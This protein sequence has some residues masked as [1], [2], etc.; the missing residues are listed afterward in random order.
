MKPGDL[1]MR[2][3]FSLLSLLSLLSL[4][5]LADDAI[6]VDHYQ[7]TPEV[8]LAQAPRFS[9]NV[10][11]GSFAPWNIDQRVNAWNLF[12]N[13]EPMVLQ[14]HG[15]CDGGG[16]DF[17]QHSTSPRFSF[18]D[19]GRSGYWDGAEVTFYRLENG[20]LRLVRVAKVKR[21][22]IGNDPVTNEKTEEKL[23]LTEAGPA[24]QAGDFYVLRDV[25]TEVSPNIRPALIDATWGTN[26]T[27]DG[28]CNFQNKV[29][30]RFD[31]KSFA[32]DGGS[33]AS[34]RMELLEASPEKPAGPWHWYVIN[35]SD[36]PHIHLRFNPGKSYKASVWLRQEGMS[37]PRALVKFGCI[38]STVVE[39][40][41][42]WRKYE[43]DLP[44][45]N[46]AQSYPNRQNDGSRL[47][48]G[49]FSKGTLWMDNL[50]VWQTDAEPFDI[51]PQ[52]TE[53]LRN[54]HPD[55]L[56]LWSGYKSPSLDYWLMDG[57]AQLN[58]GDYGKSAAP[59][60]VSLHRSLKLCTQV[61]ADPW[62]ILNP[63]FSRDEHEK[64][65]EYLGAPADYGY[66]KLR[67]KHG[68]VKPWTEVFK[69]IHLESANEAWNSIFRIN[70]SGRPEVYAAF[71]DRQF[72]EL[73]SSP[74]YQQGKF[75][76][77]ANGW[78]SAMQPQG[79]THRVAMASK[80]ADRIDVACYFG[81]WEAGKMMTEGATD[82]IYQDKL[83][84]TPIEFGRKLV[85][86]LVLDPQLTKSLC[87]ALQ[88]QPEMLAAGLSTYQSSR[89]QWTADQLTPPAGAPAQEAIR[90][91]W[92]KDTN[93]PTAIKSVLTHRRGEMERCLWVAAHKAMGSDPALQALAREALNLPDNA[94]VAPLCEGLVDHN[95]PSRLLPLLKTNEAVVARWLGGEFTDGN[96]RKDLQTFKEQ[97]EKLTYNITNELRKKL[98][99]LILAQAKSGNPVFI[100]ALK[101][102][103]TSELIQGNLNLLDYVTRSMFE[104]PG[105]RRTEQLMRTMK[106]DPA[107][108]ASVVQHL[109]QD[110][111]IFHESAAA[112]ME[113]FARSMASLY[114][115]QESFRPYD[116]DR[117]LVKLLPAEVARELLSRLQTAV[118]ATKGTFSRESQIF[119]PAM[120]AAALGD[121]GPAKALA[122]HADA[123]ALLET[124]MSGA[125]PEPF[126]EAARKDTLFGDNLIQALS[127]KASP[128]A[129][130]LAVYEGG[131]GYSLPGPN[132]PPSEDD[133]NIGKSLVMGTANLDVF[134]QFL[135]SGASPMGYY[136]FK[137]GSHWASHNNPIDMIPYPSW[138]S[139]QMVNAECRGDL[140]KVRRVSGTTV[141]VPDK[142]I[143]RTT[144]SGQS[145]ATVTGRKNVP[146]TACHV[147]RDGNR[148]AILLIN[149]DLSGI[150]RI[151]LDLPFEGSHPAQLTALTHPDP[152]T[153]NRSAYNVKLSRRDGPALKNGM[154]VD[155]PPASVYVITGVAD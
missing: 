147:Y 13:L 19:C 141:D 134:M 16:T 62:L 149:R 24:I 4:P 69:T 29:K 87:A 101:R 67:A 33:T 96:A 82:E 118:N 92:A 49:G 135:L 85:D 123:V 15:Q 90:G 8:A 63:L 71:A 79:W 121:T 153:H 11:F 78:D 60:G 17:A 56:R 105:E 94:I 65:M 32:P 30:W 77:I 22:V 91:L 108:A 23:Y 93:L 74:F 12:Y 148:Y 2:H 84:T 106:A 26:F 126:L 151:E 88:D 20:V 7:V 70:F 1:P 89:V 53:A 58:G 64:L 14:H 6:P 150:R 98:S 25:R 100:A 140:L 51:L 39:V 83:F 38:T 112:V 48:I 81:G 131:P 124:M 139:L 143:M 50:L 10:E 57:H 73:K 146:V 107:F 43:F 75:D 115:N 104:E 109:A 47:L 114:S 116:E 154:R 46:P 31:T 127:Q 128:D 36:E 28:W 132:K 66:G 52:F 113:E 120:I 155:L 95:A 35:N 61:G 42:E 145:K 55:S 138:L 117:L 86:A 142:E 133:E 54:F 44:W 129:K 152:K 122:G 21:S 18:W 102:E 68:Q 3:G 110:T 27:L 144:N 119:L 9:V 76:M 40:G 130:G 97:Q 37:D 111:S 34:L 136:N 72:L 41:N 125:L 99:E 137:S 59:V 103:T 5:A 45:E 80:H